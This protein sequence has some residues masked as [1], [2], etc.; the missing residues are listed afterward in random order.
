MLEG[1]TQVTLA[2]K[3]IIPSSVRVFSRD[4]S[5]KYL[6]DED[7]EVASSGAIEYTS[8]KLISRNT[9]SVVDES[10]TLDSGLST[11]KPDFPR[12]VHNLVVRTTSP[13]KTYTQYEDYVYDRYSNVLRALPGGTLPRNGS[14]ILIDYD[15]GIA[16]GEQVIVRCNYADEEYLKPDTFDHL[17]PETEV[18]GYKFEARRVAKHSD[19]N[20]RSIEYFI[21]FENVIWLSDPKDRS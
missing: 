19:P 17:D 9:N 7:F 21:P 14:T 15:Y 16:D 3:G 12:G 18:F 20:K 2:K 5:T 6:F 10:F 11:Y 8:N 4:E 1:S 13:E